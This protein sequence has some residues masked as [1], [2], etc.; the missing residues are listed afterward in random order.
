MCGVCQQT[1]E[2]PD[3]L[4]ALCQCPSFLPGSLLGDWAGRL[5]TLVDLGTPH[6]TASG[7]QSFRRSA[8]RQRVILLH[9][10]SN[11]VPREKEKQ[12]FFYNV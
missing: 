5:G 8:T 7:L 4:S 9:Q 10:T 2:P 11:N 1:L 3:L 12:L 6:H